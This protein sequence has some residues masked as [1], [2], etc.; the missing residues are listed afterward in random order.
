MPSVYRFAYGLQGFQP[1]YVNT[2]EIIKVIHRSQVVKL[3]HSR[4]G[5]KDV[6]AEV[7]EH[8]LSTVTR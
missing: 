1:L 5:M 2:T 7:I 8:R 6:P 4:W 3:E